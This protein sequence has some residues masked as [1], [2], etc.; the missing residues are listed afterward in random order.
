MVID[1]HAYNINIRRDSF[2]GKILFEAHVKELPDLKEYG[3]SY[4][5]AYGLAIDAI[6]TTAEAFSEKGRKFPE[7]NIPMDDFSG[8]VTLRLPRSLHR[9]LAKTAEQEEVSLNQFLV[10]ILSNFSGY[11]ASYRNLSEHNGSWH[12]PSIKDQE[13]NSKKKSSHLR[14]VEEV[15]LQQVAN[16]GWN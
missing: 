16:S 12:T 6:E 15:N 5:E 2:E 3:E 7:P 8:R 13:M 14:L 1:P 9:E 11:S 4:E 10:S